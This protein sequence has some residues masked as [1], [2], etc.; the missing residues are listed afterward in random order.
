MR[1][2]KK[3]APS[4]L[5]P[6]RF[7]DRVEVREL[8]RGALGIQKLVT[9]F[10]LEHAAARRDECDPGNAGFETIEFLRQTGGF[11]LIISNGTIFDGD[12]G[13]HNAGG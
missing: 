12:P 13:R 10:D 11:G 2:G 1:D 8:T 3:P 5:R 7:D 6:H 4:H 9:Q